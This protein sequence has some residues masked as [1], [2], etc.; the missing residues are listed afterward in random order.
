MIVLGKTAYV[1]QNENDGGMFVNIFDGN[2]AYVAGG[3]AGESSEFSWDDSKGVSKALAAQ[4]EDAARAKFMGDRLLALMDA[5]PAKEFSV[6]FVAKTG[7]DVRGLV[8]DYSLTGRTG[9][10]NDKASVQPNVELYVAR[11]EALKIAADP[12][13][14]YVHRGDPGWG[15]GTIQLP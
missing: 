7:A 9:M 3:G 8:K 5:Q 4:S 11:G 13:V 6:A 2:G 1:I 12:R 15:Y 10:M 14:Y